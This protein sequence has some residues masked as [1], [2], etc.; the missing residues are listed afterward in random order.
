[1]WTLKGLVVACL[2][3]TMACSDNRALENKRV[4]A[5]S[6]SSKGLSDKALANV[7]DSQ[8]FASHLQL[9]KN[10]HILTTGK[11][12]LGETNQLTTEAYALKAAIWEKP[13]IETC[14]ESPR[15][16][17]TSQMSQVQQAITETWQQASKLRFTGWKQCPQT[18]PVGQQVIRIQVDDSGPRTLGL[19]NQLAGIEHGM[20]LNFTFLHWSPTCQTMT[21][22]CIKGIA[23]HE[24]G[25][26]IG[27]AHEQ[28]RPDKPGE[29]QDPAQGSNGD[30]LLT[31]YDPNSVMNYCNKKY[32]NDGE[33][34]A[35]DK[36]AVQQ[37]YGKP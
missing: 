5:S 35:L 3:L 12:L 4:A 23:V 27:F 30:L 1:M 9:I 20:L 16:T 17:F 7:T 13:Q 28:N 2:V 11:Y 21:D 15:Q 26:A 8:E 24:F 33:L 25:H 37:L 31:P 19:G 18:S 6:D 29:C 22:Y 32:N 36:D 14:W 34:S 10:P